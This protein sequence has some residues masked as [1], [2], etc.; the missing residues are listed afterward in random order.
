LFEFATF[1]IEAFGIGNLLTITQSNQARDS[2]VN[3][4]LI[5]G[6]RQGVNLNIHQQRNSPSS[7]A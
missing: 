7:S 6:L 5:R 2:Q 1:G 4:D 3:P